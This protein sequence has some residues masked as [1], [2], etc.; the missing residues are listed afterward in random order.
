MVLEEAIVVIFAAQKKNIGF[1]YGRCLKL[2]CF[3]NKLIHEHTPNK[4]GGTGTAGYL[5]IPQDHRL[6]AREGS[7]SVGRMARG[8]GHTVSLCVAGH[9]LASSNVTKPSLDY[10]ELH[11]LPLTVSVSPMFCNRHSFTSRLFSGDLLISFGTLG[12]W[13]NC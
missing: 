6:R 4:Q 5:K 1:G 12:L 13:G 8:W 2:I 7:V 10:T 11:K 9:P 3:T